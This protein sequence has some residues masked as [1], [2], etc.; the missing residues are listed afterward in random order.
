[1]TRDN[2]RERRNHDNDYSDARTTNGRGPEG[3]CYE[4]SRCTTAR[5]YFT[6]DEVGPEGQTVEKVAKNRHADGTARRGSKTEKILELLKR[7]SGATLK[8]IVKATAWQPHSVRGFLS[9]T[10]RKKLGIRVRS[11][12][13]VDAERCYRIASK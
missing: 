11:S 12:K 13:H 2:C 7:P 1:M 8:E 4:G 6:E 9:G 5:R 3:C 10:L